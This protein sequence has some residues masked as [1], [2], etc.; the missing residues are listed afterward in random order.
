M[1]RLDPNT[2][3]VVWKLQPV[4]FALDGD[5]DWASGAS[6]MSAT[7]GP[8]SASTMKDGWSY[9][10][11]AGS[12]TAGPPSVRWQ[13]PATG[14]PFTGGDGTV[15]GDTRYLKPGAAWGDVFITTDG[16]EM[17]TLEP[18][19]P[20]TNEQNPALQPGFTRLHALN[21]CAGAMRLIRW[22]VDVPG[23]TPATNYQ[24]GPPTVSRGIVYVGTA[25]GHLVAIADPSAWPAQG[26]RCSRP[27]VSNTDCEPNHFYLVPN[28]TVLL[29]LPLGAGPIPTEPALAGDRVFVSTGSGR[30]V[31]LK[32]GP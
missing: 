24:V 25:K 17:L 31:M 5:P 16:G 23:T 8:L 9:A 2:G 27:D 22:I 3:A 12:G 7:C 6:L 1:L 29:D 10:A 30:V 20:G 11:F 32:P 14:F 21:V 26:S 4:P 15:H 28:P 18:M 13:F 19:Y